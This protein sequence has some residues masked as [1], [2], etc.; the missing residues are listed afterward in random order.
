MCVIGYASSLPGICGMEKIQRWPCGSG[1]MLH[2]ALG[3]CDASLHGCEERIFKTLI[4]K[5]AL[6]L[7]Y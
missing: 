6:S 5:H 7:S 4:F 1:E 2:F 3:L